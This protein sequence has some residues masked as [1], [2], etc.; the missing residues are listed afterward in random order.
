MLFQA[1]DQPGMHCAARSTR[2]R[3][4]NQDCTLD[5][6]SVFYLLLKCFPLSFFVFSCEGDHS[7]QQLGFASGPPIST[8]CVLELKKPTTK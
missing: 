2:L 3:G 6:L 1:E 7:L 4:Q 8:V 5:C